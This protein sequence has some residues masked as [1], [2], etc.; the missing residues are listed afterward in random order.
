MSLRFDLSPIGYKNQFLTA[1]LHRC[2]GT[3]RRNASFMSPSFGQNFALCANKAASSHVSQV[4]LEIGM[5][6]RGRDTGGMGRQRKEGET[7]ERK[8]N[9]EHIQL[10]VATVSS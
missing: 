5:D 7:R 8:I 6:R 9:K 2:Y 4:Q 1:Q 3:K 10:R